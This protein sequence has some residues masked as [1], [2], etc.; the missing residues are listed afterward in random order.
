MLSLLW[1]LSQLNQ[2]FWEFWNFD[3]MSLDFQFFF[4]FSFQ[5]VPLVL[6]TSSLSSRETL[7]LNLSFKL[8]KLFPLIFIKIWEIKVIIFLIIFVI[9]LFIFVVVTLNI[10]LDFYFIIFTFFILIIV[11]LLVIIIFI[12]FFINFGFGI[13]LKGV[14]LSALFVFVCIT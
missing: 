12:F 9:Y 6:K 7:I 13:L 1:C 14:L 11:F 4:Y 3:F 2:F 10:N 8:K 5:D